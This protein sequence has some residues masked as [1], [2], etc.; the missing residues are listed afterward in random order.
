MVTSTVP[1]LDGDQGSHGAVGTR[2]LAL[3]RQ[4]IH[5]FDSA[6]GERP[7]VC[8]QVLRSDLL[9]MCVCACV[10]IRGR[11]RLNEWEGGRK[12]IL[13]APELSSPGQ[14]G[15]VTGTMEKD[16][17]LRGAHGGPIGSAL[18]KR[19]SSLSTCSLRWHARSSPRRPLQARTDGAGVRPGYQLC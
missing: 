18:L 12:E 14:R 15:P 3:V 4:E 19:L 10:S 5:P 2:S 11:A 9:Q 13:S 16:C 1:Q 6:Y 17:R 7:Q 8:I